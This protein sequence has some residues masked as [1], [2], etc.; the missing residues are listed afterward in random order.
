M[1]VKLHMGCIDKKI[2]GF[3]SEI[4]TLLENSWTFKNAGSGREFPKQ[5]I[6]K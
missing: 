5:Q 3:S 4:R 1:L 2:L 6:T